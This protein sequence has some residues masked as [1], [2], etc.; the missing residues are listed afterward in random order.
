MEWLP[1]AKY[2]FNTNYHTF[3]EFTP[4]KALYDYPPPRLL[5]FIPGTTRVVAVE[6]L[7]AHRQ[8]VFGLLQDNIVAA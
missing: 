2:W 7:L 8:Q 4:F 5:E 6:E 3:A 1:S